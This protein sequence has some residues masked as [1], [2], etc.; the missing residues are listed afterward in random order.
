[1]KFQH[2]K[3]STWSCINQL[4]LCYKLIDSKW[5]VSGTD[6]AFQEIRHSFKFVKRLTPTLLNNQ[7]YC[8][9]LFDRTRCSA[10]SVSTFCAPHCF[11]FSFHNTWKVVQYS[12]VASHLWKSPLKKLCENVR[13]MKD[14]SRMGYT[15]TFGLLINPTHLFNQHLMVSISIYRWAVTSSEVKFINDEVKFYMRFPS[16]RTTLSVEVLHGDSRS[17]T[18]PPSAACWSSPSSDSPSFGLVKT[19]RSWSLLVWP[20]Q[21]SIR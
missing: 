10:V 2:W 9:S 21:N 12:L 20:C 3:W 7:L 11:C 19:M 6:C 15:T 5:T 4:W 14:F 1:M 18:Q 13:D 8:Q 16:L 17:Y